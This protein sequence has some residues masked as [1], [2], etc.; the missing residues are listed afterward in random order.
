MLLKG[1]HSTPCKVLSGVS[2]GTVMAPV[3]FTL[4]ASLIP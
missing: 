1:E 4:M 3:L 2:Q